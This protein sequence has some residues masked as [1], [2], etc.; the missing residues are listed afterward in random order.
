MRQHG[1]AILKL[2]EEI[3]DLKPPE[4]P[5]DEQLEPEESPRLVAADEPI[6]NY[7][8][9]CDISN[10]FL[11]PLWHPKFDGLNIISVRALEVAD[12]VLVTAVDASGDRRSIM[13]ERYFLEMADL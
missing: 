1:L 13:L 4:M 8:S 2:S 10:S 6:K 11:G 7:W 5:P 12:A 9:Q 3:F